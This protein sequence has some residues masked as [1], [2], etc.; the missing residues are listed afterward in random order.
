MVKKVVIIGGGF[1]GLSCARNLANN[2][3]FEVTVLDKQN[4]HLFQPL[5]YQL[6]SAT[7]AATDIARSLRGILSKAKNV[8]VFLDLSLIHI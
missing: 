6:A 7:L 2:P 5:L 1:A 3:N 8:S 4:H